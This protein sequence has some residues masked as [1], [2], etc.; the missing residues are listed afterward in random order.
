MATTMT[1]RGDSGKAAMAMARETGEFLAEV[2][3][4]KS[5]LSP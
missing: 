2:V 3:K 5:V 1:M 4:V